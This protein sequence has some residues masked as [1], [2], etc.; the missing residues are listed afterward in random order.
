[1]AEPLD[2]IQVVPLGSFMYGDR[3]I[4]ITA[5]S[6]QEI[7][8]NFPQ[9]HSI[10]VDF[11][12]Q[13]V[14]S[15]YNGDPAPAM[16]WIDKL[17][18]RGSGLFAH[19]E[20]WTEDGITFI[21]RDEYRYFS[22]VLQFKQNEQKEMVDGELTSVAMTNMPFFSEMNG[23]FKK[24]NIKNK[25][26]ESDMEKQELQAEIKE[27]KAKLET[28]E[29]EVAK[30][31]QKQR[32]AELAKMIL[33]AGIEDKE[34]IATFKAIGNFSV[35]LMTKTLGLFSQLE[36]ENKKVTKKKELKGKKEDTQTVFNPYKDKVSFAKAIENKELFEE[37]IKNNL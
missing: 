33:D 4:V 15:E 1:M 31:K 8:D 18:V 13:T 6:L 10:V 36:K 12:H 3:E 19:I 28:T 9:N 24:Q 34:K 2:W 32:E 23:L 30:A 29:M 20:K 25:K 37:Y 26:E 5:K 22:P 16:G 27:L 35:E 14:N 17:E 7:V 11:E 21:K